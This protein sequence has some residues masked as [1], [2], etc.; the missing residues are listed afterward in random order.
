[1]FVRFFAFPSLILL[2]AFL[3]VDCEKPAPPANTLR[4]GIGAE[5]ASLDPQLMQG[6]AEGRVLSSLYEGLVLPFPNL[7]RNGSQGVAPKINSPSGGEGVRGWGIDNDVSPGVAER[8]EISKDGCVYT[9]HLRADAKWSNPDSIGASGESVTAQDFVWSWKRAMSPAI[10]SPNASLFDSI[11]GAKAYRAGKIDWSGVG[12]GAPDA[13]TLVVTLDRPNPVFLQILAHP[14]FYPLHR[15]TLEKYG[16]EN[17][18][19][20][21]WIKPG[22]LVSNGPF[23]LVERAPYQRIVVEKNPN[24]WGRQEIKLRRIEFYPIDNRASEEMAFLSGGLDITLTLPLS[25]VEAYRRDPR[26]RIDPALQ[27]EYIL[28]NTRRAPLDNKSVRQTLSMALDREALCK[29][30]LRAGQAP[31]YRFVPPGC[32]VHDF[33]KNKGADDPKGLK[34]DTPLASPTCLQE[35]SMLAR[36]ILETTTHPLPLNSPVYC[37]NSSEARKTVA[38]TL[39][40]QWQKNLGIAVG[41][42]NLEWKTFL[43]AKNNGDFMMARGG[44]SADINDPSNFLELFLSDNPNNT[45]GWS[46]PGYDKLVRERK[47]TEAEKILLDELPCIPLYF[48]PNV[49]LISPRVKGWEVSPLDLHDWRK[50]RVE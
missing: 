38:E 23:R 36:K 5:P 35:N 22:E 42:E 43:N 8:W 33:L 10:A 34:D 48:N 44:W 13:Q 32:G 40:A 26:L 7:L 39:Q 2:A 3:L 19:A 9:F 50:V 25:K 14:V 12:I 46:N 18:R 28:L 37:F 16:A 6:M 17:K 21:N 49:Y 45:T 20:V 1:M 15:A 11:A 24:Y 47:F 30:V 31:A 41:L 29:K 4:V 27:V